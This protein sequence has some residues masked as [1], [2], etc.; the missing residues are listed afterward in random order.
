MPL[1]SSKQREASLITFLKWLIRCVLFALLPILVT[2]GIGI[3]GYS[4]MADLH[5]PENFHMAGLYPTG[6]EPTCEIKAESVRSFSS[7][8]F[9]Y[10]SITLLS[11]SAVF[12]VPVIHRFLHKF[13]VGKK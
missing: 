11:I 8:H 7:L 1:E 3:P 9:L 10:S 12:F 2:L 13:Q 6:V 4:Y 5:W